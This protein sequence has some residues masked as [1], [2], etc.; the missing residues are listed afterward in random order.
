MH[1]SVRVGRLCRFRA[2]IARSSD[3]AALPFQAVHGLCLRRNFAGV[4]DIGWIGPGFGIGQVRGYGC[5]GLQVLG[6]QL[7]ANGRGIHLLALLRWQWI[8]AECFGLGQ[9]LIMRVAYLARRDSAGRA[10]L[11][12]VIGRAD[13]VMQPAHVLGAM[14]A[15][16]DRTRLPAA[17]CRSSAVPLFS[18]LY[19]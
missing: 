13:C 16:T 4:L 10:G 17:F 8:L 7:T 9:R 19:C 1:N 6:Q 14:T 3:D 5:G 15:A 11:Q 18:K 12:C 2:C